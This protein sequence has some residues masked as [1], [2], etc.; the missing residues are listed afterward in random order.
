M[1]SWELWILRGLRRAT[2]ITAG[3]RTTSHLCSCHPNSGML[4]KG[5]AW[6]SEVSC[7]KPIRIN[8][9]Q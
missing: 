1:F 8:S 6:S 5:Y 7:A 2:V 9:H 4:W 3:C